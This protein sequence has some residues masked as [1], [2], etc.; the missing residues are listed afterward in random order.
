MNS[1]DFVRK[2]ECASQNESQGAHEHFIDLCRLL[3]V[4]TPNEA[5]PAGHT[6]CFERSVAKTNGR[7]GRADVWKKDCFAWEY[8]SPGLDLGNAF[9]QLQR[10]APALGNPPLLIVSDLRRIRIHTNWTYV[11]STTIDIPAAELLRPERRALLKNAFADPDRLRPTRTRQALTAEAAS[12]FAVLAARL[13][14][15]GHAPEV[16]AHFLIRLVFCMF[17][18]SIGLLH[19]RLFSRLLEEAGR[20]PEE[21]AALAGALFRSMHSGGRVGYDKVA[22]FNGGLFDDST[23]LPLE[24]GDIALV[25]E[26]A[27]MDWS[28]IDPS[29]LGTLFERGLTPARREALA[30]AV[31]TRDAAGLSQGAVGIHYT[32]DTIIARLIEPVILRPLRREWEGVHDKLLRLLDGGKRNRREAEKTYK[33]FLDRLRAFRVLDPACGSGNF[34]YLALM[35]LKDLEHEVL[36]EGEA[37]GFGREFALIGPE[38]VLGIEV[39][40]LAVE[41]ARISVWIGEIQWRHRRG[42]ALPSNPVLKPMETVE[43]RDALI[44]LVGGEADWPKADVIVGNPP[45]LGDKAMLGALGEGYVTRLRSLFRGR[46]PGAADLVCY[47]FEKAR[48]MVEQGRVGRVGLVSTNSIRG[49]ANRAVLDRIRTGGQ[50]YEAW[51]DEPWEVDGAAVRVSLLCFGPKS[52]DDPPRLD[53][54]EVPEIFADLTGGGVDLTTAKGLVENRDVCFQGPVKVGSFEVPGDVARRWLL[55]PTNPNGRKNSDV[56][57]PWS[58]GNDITKRPSDTWIVDFSDMD[59][60]EASLYESP[61]AHV[62][63]HVKPE[64]DTNNDTSRRTYWWRLG[65]QGSDLRHATG[66]SNRYIA[67]PRVARHRLFVWLNTTTLPDSRLCIIARG[68][69]TTFGIVHSRFHELWSVALGGRHGVGNDPQYTPKTGFETFPFPEG[70]TPDRRASDYADDPRAVVI[71]VAARRLNDL[72]EAWL[73]PLDLVERVPEVVP[74]YP[75]RVLARSAKA[76]ETLKTRTLTNLYN[77]RP[78]W[79]AAAHRDLDAAVAA[80]YGWP[81]EIGD[82]EALRHLLALNHQRAAAQPAPEKKRRPKERDRD[83]LNL[84]L[85]ISGGGTGKAEE[86]R[87]PLPAVAE[88]MERPAAARRAKRA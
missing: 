38:A 7:P 27:Q 4:P 9:T 5:D 65:R 84:L 28:E 58:N 82:E 41:L 67:T 75:D 70:L 83:Q 80:A 31:A 21:F 56:V 23:A 15:R 43:H 16:V 85:P 39:N 40:P 60:A 68:D 55:E 24:A 8:K 2:W 61:F 14:R 50:F 37:L 33:G 76:A 32:P 46:L 12:R 35:A 63:C 73:N 81:A 26:A 74:G 57:R 25:S 49:G 47:W 13:E 42:L 22:W 78:Q 6:Y 34:L 64:R 17:A 20:A 62:Y 52:L 87:P 59:K 11:V 1:D 66:K 19:G 72:R 53:G 54:R 51:S 45:F 10:Y 79:L 71:A 36:V 69:D 3:E 88:P 44:N 48:A 30:R 77:Q 29:I 86:Q 18:E